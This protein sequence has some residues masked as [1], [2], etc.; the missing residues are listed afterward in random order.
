MTTLD[1]IQTPD[2]LANAVQR[3]TTVF[4]GVCILLAG[5]KQVLLRKLP[6]QCYQGDRRNKLDAAF[7]QFS[8]GA[9]KQK[10]E[11][12]LLGDPKSF[13]LSNIVGDVRSAVTTAL[14]DSKEPGVSTAISETFD[15]V[16]TGKLADAF[17]ANVDA[18]RGTVEQEQE[19]AGKSKKD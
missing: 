3:Q 14:G 6:T 8:D 4:T 9:N 12:A 10:F 13:N 15:M 19:K 11:Q 17:K 18:P 1:T 16:D 5:L 2:D 7:N